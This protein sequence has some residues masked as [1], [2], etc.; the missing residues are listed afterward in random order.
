MKLFIV[1][2]GETDWNV[3]GRFQGR[4][5]TELSELGRRQGEKAAEYL[6]GHTFEAVVSGPLKRTLETGGL[7][8]AA[9]GCETL[10]V[11]DE[12]AEICHGDWEGLLSDDVQRRWP[13]LVA[14]WHELPHTVVMPGAGGESLR[15]V[16][17]RALT[18]V[19]CIRKKYPGD[20]C[21]VTHDAVIKALLCH[22]LNASLS[23]YWRCQIANCSLTIAELRDGVPPRVS[24][25]GDAHYLGIGFEL[26]EQKGM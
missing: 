18:A 15:S 16:Q 26:P 24:L 11:M 10:E 25:M 3:E 20:V 8:A 21:V 22:F 1:R 23:A 12:L 14:L 17:I 2:H 19:E 5:D 7:I 9:C 13:G 6:S 4:L